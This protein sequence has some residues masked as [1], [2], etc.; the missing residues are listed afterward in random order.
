MDEKW[1]EWV[2]GNQMEELR[3]NMLDEERHRMVFGNQ[4]VEFRRGIWW[5]RNG[6]N[7]VFGN[8][9][10]ELRTEYDGWETDRTSSPEGN[11][12][13]LHDLCCSVTWSVT[14][15]IVIFSRINFLSE[16]LK[17]LVLWSWRIWAF[18]AGFWNWVSSGNCDGSL[19]VVFSVEMR[20]EELCFC[21]LGFLVSVV[22]AAV[23]LG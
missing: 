21:F 15:A 7:G 19:K 12:R 3:R 16:N 17:R 18:P 10:V 1:T 5:M 2:F 23:A 14:T 22:A 9:M 13:E 11:H 6:Q 20:M 4:M 8:Q